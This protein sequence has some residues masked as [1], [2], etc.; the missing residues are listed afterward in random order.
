MPRFKADLNKLLPTWYCAVVHNNQEWQ[1]RQ[2]LIQ[3]GI[4]C[5]LPVYLKCD[6]ATHYHLVAKLLFH[7]YVFVHLDDPSKWP[8]IR[9]TAGISHLLLHRPHLADYDMPSPAGS[10]AIATLQ[11]VAANLDVR[12]RG[13][14]RNLPSI[15]LAAPIPVID[16]G[17][18]VRV[19][20]DHPLSRLVDDRGALVNWSDAERAEVVIKIFGR[21]SPIEF[22]LKD[23]ELVPNAES[24]H[25]S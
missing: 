19:R 5:M 15:A 3:R 22:Y 9:W 2:R 14:P 25:R 8:Q 4:P 16:A 20:D 18:H 12:Q 6:K 24:P 11:Q 10:A 7:R 1:V 17:C 23:L 13:I 21:D